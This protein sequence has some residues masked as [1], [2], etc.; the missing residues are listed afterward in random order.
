MWIQK[1][2]AADLIGKPLETGFPYNLIHDLNVKNV[3]GYE[4]CGDN[5][6]MWAQHAGDPNYNLLNECCQAMNGPNPG[7]LGYTKIGQATMDYIMQ[8][9]E[10]RDYFVR[11]WQLMAEV[12]QQHPSAFAVESMNEPM[13]I[14]RK[15]M[16]DTWRAISNAVTQVV[17]DMSVAL[18]DIG[19]GS[20]LPW[21]ATKYFHIEDL[22]ISSDTLKWIHSSNNLFYAWHWYGGPLKVE[23][24]IHAMLTIQQDWNVPSFATEFMSCDI[25][26]NA[27]SANISHSY[28]HYSA[29]CTT[30][31]A[32]GNRKV[33]ED[34]FGACILGW[35]GGTVN[36][37]CK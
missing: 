13:S 3:G 10:G 11:Y 5:E 36:K 30:G 31:P 9:G 27:S 15:W 1:K 35:A 19:E 33:P 25:W 7:A 4:H 26:N 22:D 6:T 34:T 37:A 16:F 8:P 17:P 29:Y 18:L 24:A 12:V 21:W 20:F 14:R 23:D 2:A 28:W 32:F